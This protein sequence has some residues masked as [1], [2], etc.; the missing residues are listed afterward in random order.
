MKWEQEIFRDFTDIWQPPNDDDIHEWATKHV[1]LPSGYNPSGPFAI[2]PSQYMIEPLQALK[3]KSIREVNI[4]ASPRTAKTLTAELWLMWLIAN[5]PG[6]TLWLQSGDEM[7]EK[8]G[9]MRMVPLIKHCEPVKTLIPDAQRFALTNKKYKFPHMEIHLSGA[10]INALQSIGYTNIIY[11]EVWLTEQGFIDEA[12]TRLQDFP[13][14]SKFLLISQ[15]GNEGTDWAKTFNDAPIYEWGFMCPK[16]DRP[17]VFSWS[18]RRADGSYSGVNWD[19]L[20]KVKGQWDLD[21]AGDSA[22]IE[23]HYCR[24]HINDTPLERRYLNDNGLYIN[25]KKDGNPSRKSFRW[26][27]LANMKTSLKELVVEY[28]QADACREYNKTPMTI[29]TQKRLAK[30]PETKKERNIL[31]IMSAEYDPAEGDIK[32]MT[33]DVQKETMPWLIRA[34][35][36]DGSSQF[37]KRGKAMDWTELRKIQIENQIKDQN[38]LIDSGHKPTEVYAECVKNGHEGMV[39]GKKMWLSWTATKGA[40][41]VDFEHD[42]NVRKF[43]AKESRGDP[44]LGKGIKG[45]TCPLYRWSNLSIKNIL[46]YLISCKGVTWTG[47]LK[48]DVT[49]YNEMNSEKKEFKPDNTGKIKEI[50]NRQGKLVNDVWD[51][52]ALQ[53]LA[54]YMRGLLG[55]IHIKTPTVEQDKNKIVE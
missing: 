12:R 11:D 48:E 44:N 4:M 24:H 19:P 35:K 37:V 13:H 30:T 52:E 49:Y 7:I 29:F 15:G 9:P 54:A 22:Y 39:K 14:T 23:C 28:L 5:N 36:N 20:C 50:W 25:T 53:V 43:Y 51:L 2:G 21:K 8:I 6:H 27:A 46:E 40:G 3:D 1:V 17:Q 16:C 45:K 55:S 33:C 42:G 41:E 32:F 18:F 31:N 47:A 26:N 38:V 10:K 34:W